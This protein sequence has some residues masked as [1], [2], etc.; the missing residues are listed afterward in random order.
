[1]SILRLLAYSAL[2]TLTISQDKIIDVVICF[3]AVVRD[4]SLPFEDMLN[5]ILNAT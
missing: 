3:T 4:D 2:D 1:M 5:M